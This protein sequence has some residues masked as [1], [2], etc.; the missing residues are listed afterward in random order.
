M[1]SEHYVELS[2]KL[3]GKYFSHNS[4]EHFTEKNRF[5][6]QANIPMEYHVYCSII[7]MKA[8]IGLLVS[9]IVIIP[10]HFLLM[11][12]ITLYGL[13]LIP[14][15]TAAI[16]GGFYA[17]RPK[18]LIRKRGRN[19]DLFLPY[20]IN[21][22]SSM[23]V[24]GISPAEIF[25]S[26]STMN[27]YGEIQQEARKIAKDI[28]VMGTD[29]ISAMKNAIE[30]SPSKK[31]RSFLQGI[32]GTIQSGS[33]LHVYLSSVVEKNM[34]EDLIDRKKDL[35]LLGVIGEVFVISVIAFPIFLVIILTTM[36]FFGGSMETSIA[37]LL[38]FSF[39]ILPV[40]YIG[41]YMLISSTSLEEINKIRSKNG[42]SLRSYYRENKKYVHIL[43]G[44]L[45]LLTIV[46]TA[47]GLGYYFD[48][49]T[50]NL[51]LFL[52]CIFLGVLLLLGPIGIYKYLEIKRRREIQ[53]RLPEF[54]TEI[55]D[56][57]STGMTIFDA[58][59]TTDKGHY[60]ELKPEINKMKKQLSWQVS[61]KEVFSDFSEKMKSAI[62]ERV[63]LMVNRG[64]ITG[65]NTPKIF[66]AAAREVNQVNMLEN[67][68]KQN[69][70]I[71][72]MVIILCFFI[73]LAIIV[74]LDK[75]VFMSFIELQHGQT[76][77]VGNIMSLSTVD[78]FQLKYA[79]YSFVFVQSIGAGI[80]A[81]FMMDGKP[82]SGVRISCI[83][84]LIS[85]AVFKLLF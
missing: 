34:Q 23:A 52:D 78:A 3:F 33:D 47:M 36:G 38:V 15:A 84:G 58:I 67:Q 41:F 10:I 2:T 21:Y 64:L 66:K 30:I 29:S 19:I 62:I 25:Q 13:I 68:R 59:K 82:S 63:I 20:A 32:I 17:Y 18:Y 22:V 60:G 42:Y 1:K 69:M 6:A 26:L 56:S 50:V 49:F 46:Y 28:M 40:I 72:T 12:P 85:F 83:L 55:G 27:V 61:I 73:F 44:C 71:Y 7:V 11:M 8:L 14:P 70:S 43:I 54:L 37:T 75:T 65:G 31:F 57:L 9:L 35:D 76:A 80:L 81:G 53:E 77:Q 24:S 48:Y 16:L 74:I 79:L 5:L 4:E 39:G 51:Y 45:A